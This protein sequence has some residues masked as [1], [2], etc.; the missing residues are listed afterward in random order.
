M[1]KI[2]KLSGG[3]GNQL[4]QYFQAAQDVL[5]NGSDLVIDFKD[6]YLGK[7]NHGSKISSINL[8]LNY[9]WRNHSS[10][11]LVVF[12]GRV[13]KSLKYRLF[14]KHRGDKPIKQLDSLICQSSKH[15]EYVLEKFPDWS[16]T[17][18]APSNWYQRMLSLAGHTEFIAV[19]V[20]RGDYLESRNIHTIG[21]LDLEFYLKGISMLQSKIGTLPVW[22]F[23]DDPSFLA[24][25]LDKFPVNCRLVV[26]PSDSDPS[27]SIMLMSKAAG[28]VLSNSTFSWWGARFAPEQSLKI[29]PSP[30]FKNLPAP[31]S[32]I[33]KTWNVM[34][35]IWANE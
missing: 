25:I 12:S 22:I 33:P 18:A 17:L 20:R 5:E 29:A 10:S 16:P 1:L 23:T 3:I 35:S 32:L 28:F 8:P 2:Y 24:R 14:L 34:E 27:E 30:W 31:E 15:Y 26:P 9:T 13:L 6:I 11:T 7:V 19:H 4:F 21:L